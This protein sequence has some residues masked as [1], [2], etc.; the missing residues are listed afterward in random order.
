MTL[1]ESLN[2]SELAVKSA[3]NRIITALEKGE[4]PWQ[5]TWKGY[6]KNMGFP[7]NVYTKK[8]YF[9]ISAVLL[10]QASEKLGFKSNW[11]GTSSQFAAL[12]GK[13]APR[14]SHVEPGEWP[15][16]ILV[17]K[18][19]VVTGKLTLGSAIVYNSEQ[20]VT[21][22]ETLTPEPKLNPNYELAERVMNSVGAEVEFNNDG[23]AWYY[24]PPDDYITVP[25]KEAFEDTLG[26]MPAYYETLAHE[27]MH[28]TEPRLGFKGNEAAR[29]LRAEI[30][31]TMLGEELGLPH[32]C[33]F[34]HIAK[35][36]REW[37]RCM[38]ENP[39]LII[40]ICAS[41]SN[42]TDLIL[43][44]SNLLEERFNAA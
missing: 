11:W 31:S 36:R 35:W 30:G 38:Q 2:L 42:A 8:K 3:N 34:S 40:E 19:D 32:S 20:L 13:I 7:R 4:V 23:E 25:S 29:E 27:L 5:R 26:G 17:Y 39:N 10:I 9:G 6:G 21:P 43:D 12:G 28:W 44:R 24:Y 14:P 22:F 15:T 18:K 37:L 16:E 33:A 1:L 41:I